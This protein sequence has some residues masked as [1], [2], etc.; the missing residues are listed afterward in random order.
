VFNSNNS[1]YSGIGVDYSTAVDRFV[2]WIN[3]SS[4]DVSGTGTAAMRMNSGNFVT[5]TGS[6]R[7]PIF[8]D[9]DNTG[10]YV[11]PAST[12]NLVRLNLNN[13]ANLGLYVET[14]VADGSTRDAIYLYENS[15]QATGRQAISWYNGGQGYYKARMWTEVGSSYAATQFGIDVAD[16]ARTLSTRFYISNGEVYA[17][18]S[19]R[20][21]IFYDS[22]NTAYYTD[23][24]STSVL[25]GLTVAG[26]T[27][28]TTSGSPSYYMARAWVNFNGV[29]V[30]A[31]RSSVNVSSITDNGVGDYF[32]N[33]TTAM[34][35]ENYVL[36]GTRCGNA[37]GSYVLGGN[38]YTTAP[39]TT[40]ARVILV[41]PGVAAG[42]D[43]FCMV[44]IFR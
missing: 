4:A 1:S 35:D 17:N 16:N 29:N 6:F 37:T 31:I 7:A 20:A 14:A 26:G 5:A 8:Y 18:G 2:F 39:T 22:N 11:D 32:I 33:F 28:A 12:S 40:A 3:G 9:S 43:T 25:N 36:L 23:P 27:I 24:A 10:Y 13:G 19:F 38:F 21:P 41:Y 15:G 42:D 44:T 34:P 30:V